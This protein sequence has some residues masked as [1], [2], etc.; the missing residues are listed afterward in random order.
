M[1]YDN[2]QIKYQILKHS[3]KRKLNYH[4]RS[5]PPS[6]LNELV[7]EY[8]D[9]KMDIFISILNNQLT[10]ESFSEL[11][12]KTIMLENKENLC[13]GFDLQNSIILS[14][15][16]FLASTLVNDNLEIDNQSRSIREFHS[17]IEEYSS[18]IKDFDFNYIN[19]LRPEKDKTI[20]N[21]IYTKLLE[22]EYK[23]YELLLRS[24]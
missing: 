12:L 8:D 20:Q 11:E 10:K 4:F 5:I 17:I 13:P 1:K 15:A 3:F 2:N 22:S 9:M 7:R 23:Q 14:K 6:L 24:S 19:N 16:A 21:Q 18:I